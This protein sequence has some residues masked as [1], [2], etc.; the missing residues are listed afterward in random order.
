MW[1]STVWRGSRWFPWAVRNTIYFSMNAEACCQLS[2]YFVFF[3]ALFL[4]RQR[5]RAKKNG[6]CLPST[7]RRRQAARRGAGFSANRLTGEYRRLC[8]ACKSGVRVT[9]VVDGLTRKNPPHHRKRE[10]WSAKNPPPPAQRVTCW[11]AVYRDNRGRL[12]LAFEA[13]GERRDCCR[14]QT[15][16]SAT[17]RMGDKSQ[18]GALSVGVPG[19][20]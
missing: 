5:K 7:T 2:Y 1:L 18:H 15:P 13:D 12:V 14:E 11:P 17:G 19:C 9:M 10:G 6:A 16:H 20:W 3:Y 8:P 4:S